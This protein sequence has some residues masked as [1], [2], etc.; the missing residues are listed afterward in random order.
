[1]IPHL[2]TLM[3]IYAILAVSLNLVVGLTGLFNLGHAAFFGIG[4][5]ASALLALAGYPYPVSLAA[6]ITLPAL[7][8][9]LVGLPTRR[10]RGDYLAMATLGFGEIARAV[11]RNW[12][13]LTRGPMGLPGIPHPSLFG[14]SIDTAGKFVVLAGSALALTWLAIEILT[15]APFGRA[16]R[17]IREDELAVQALGKNPEP[18]KLQALALGAGFAGLGGSLYAHYIAFVDPSPFTLPTT[19]FLFLLIVLG[20]LG[21]HAGSVLAAFGLLA[22]RESLRF[23]GLPPSIAAPLQQLVFSLL[24]VVLVIYRPWGFFPEPTLRSARARRA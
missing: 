9:V 14:V 12:V 5:Y 21:N 20:G 3:A 2:L 19:I 6:A 7:T 11:F 10:L 16:L 24:L 23:A 17:A 1:M 4:A 18:F 13:S 22:A 8:G 15:R